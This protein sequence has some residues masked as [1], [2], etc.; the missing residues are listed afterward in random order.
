[1]N[2]DAINWIPLFPDEEIPH[3]LG[4]ISRCMS[5][6]QKTS[7]QEHETQITKRLHLKLKAD[8]ALRERPVW[9]DRE[10]AEDDEDT[11]EEGRMDLRFLLQDPVLKP[12]PYFAVEAKRL[13][14]T[15]PT[16]WQSLV[17][18]YVKGEQ[19]MMCFITSR[20]S[21]AL[22]SGAMLGYVFDR[23]I[24]RA[25]SSIFDATEKSE[26]ILKLV[27]STPKNPCS[28]WKTLHHLGDREFAIFHLLTEV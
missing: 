14:V 20:Y 8:S 23:D 19:G 10:T 15:F 25:A 27:R 7:E 18:E 3:I 16:G 11:G 9:P 5:G 28:Q 24:P 26:K 21:K 2:G 1:M 6:I 17:S 13:H 12:P 22:C 4:A